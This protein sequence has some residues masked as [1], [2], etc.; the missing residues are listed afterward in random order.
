MI[1][2][3]FDPQ[4]FFLGV[5]S[6]ICGFILFAGSGYVLLSGVLGR[7][8]A[9][10]VAAIAFFT[11]L[12]LLSSL[13]TFGFWASGPDTQAD[14][15]P[16]GPEPGWVAVASGVD[17]ASDEYPVAQLYPAD[18]WQEPNEGQAVSV[19]PLAASIREFAAQQANEEAGIEEEIE[20]PVWAGG[21]GLPEH[22]PGEE[23][24][25]PSD[26]VVQDIRFTTDGD[27]SLGAGRVF[28]KGGGTQL[29]VI[30]RHDAGAVS[31]WSWVFLI[32]SLIGFAAHVPFL[33]R[34]E[35]RRK[36]IVTSAPAP[37][38]SEG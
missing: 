25:I 6:V 14:Q 30:A 17:P 20:I 10:L 32:G 21:N 26:F 22:E 16:R 27:T 1:A 5:L 34:E 29:T 23:P 13:W 19:D 12:A 15:G 37:W 31:A 2:S 24:F 36:G 11:V 38:R 35:K 33:D 9:Y 18:P 4:V 28:Y 7:K 3:T 8:M